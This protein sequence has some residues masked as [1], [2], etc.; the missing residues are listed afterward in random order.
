MKR[1]ALTILM[2]CF[3]SLSL[4]AEEKVKE[5]PTEGKR[6]PDRLFMPKGDFSAGA[7]FSYVDLLSNDSEYLM[8]V[9]HLDANATIMTFSPYLDYSYKNNRSVGLRAKYSSA[10]GGISKAD[11]S[12]LSDDLSF[13]LNDILADSRSIQAEIYHRAYAPLDKSSRF[14]VFTDV[15]LGYSHTRTSFSYNEESLDTYAIATGSSSPS[16][17]A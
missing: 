15:S 1:I 4:L 12:M 13:S 9:Q 8:L 16:I 11:L 7:Q 14:G 2:I 3:S 5:A 10:K 17:P 6:G